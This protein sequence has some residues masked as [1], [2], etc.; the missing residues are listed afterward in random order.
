MNFT[1]YR[2]S[3]ALQSFYSRLLEALPGKTGVAT[4]ALAGTFPFSAVAPGSAVYR[5]DDESFPRTDPLPVTSLLF[6]SPGYFDTMRIPLV[7][8]RGFTSSDNTERSSVV[9]SESL[10]KR[11][12]GDRDPVGGHIMVDEGRTR[13][14]IVG[15]AGDVRQQGLD[16]EARDQIY[17]PILQYGVLSGAV[18]VRSG[19]DPATMEQRIRDA[20]YG[21]DREQPVDDFRQLETVRHQTLAPRRLT[22]QLLTIFALLALTITASGIG[23]VVAFSVTQ[24]TQEIG[25][26]LA[27]GAEPRRVLSMVVWQ[28]MQPVLVGLVLGVGGAALLSRLLRQLLFGVTSADPITLAVSTVVVVFVAGVACVLPARRA[29][30]IDPVMALRG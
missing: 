22:M 17:G 12:W 2:S 15:V 3:A 11:Y 21:I 14:T 1:K 26:H 23:G 9:I 13:L 27:M 25:I 7:R 6:V 30:T 28:G 29:I 20:V 16:V 10:A 8:G 24:R 18:L 5:I 19:T 4:V